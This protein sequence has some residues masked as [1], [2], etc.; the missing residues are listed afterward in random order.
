[1]TRPAHTGE[2]PI[3]DTRVRRIAENAVDDPSA[4]SAILRSAVLAHVGVVIDELPYVL[5]VACAPWESPE[6]ADNPPGLLIHG[7]TGSRLFR[8]LAAGAPVCAT[9]THLDGLVLARSA[10]NS[11]MTYRSAMMMGTCEVL[12]GAAKTDALTTLTDH[13][14]PD[15]RASLRATTGREDA[16]TLVLGLAAHT[17]SVK[18]GQGGPE[19]PAEDLANSADVWAGVVP[20]V[21]AFGAPEPDELSADLP[22]P[23]YIETWP[24]PGAQLP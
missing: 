24:V 6:A 8:A 10:F 16:A 3:P 7:S 5:P 17:W 12:S 14:L 9:V 18:V 19:D 2:G 11:S 1:M 23:G 21:T 20:L 4:L 13:L 15:R 22:V